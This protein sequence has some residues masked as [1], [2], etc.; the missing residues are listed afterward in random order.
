MRSLRC[1]IL[2]Y[3]RLQKGYECYS[4]LYYF[5]WYQPILFSWS[6]SHFNHEASRSVR[7]WFYVSTYSSHLI[8]YCHYS[9]YA[10]L[11]LFPLPRKQKLVNVNIRCTSYRDQPSPHGLVTSTSSIPLSAYVSYLCSNSSKSSWDL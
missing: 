7:R 8:F 11:K 10:D 2:G 9:S 4:L 1:I 3:S 5:H 6:M